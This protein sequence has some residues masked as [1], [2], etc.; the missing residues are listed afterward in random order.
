MSRWKI[1][2]D[3]LVVKKVSRAKACKSVEAELLVWQDDKTRVGH[4]GLFF[5]EGR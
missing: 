2:D 4:Q 5:G 3:M 1:H